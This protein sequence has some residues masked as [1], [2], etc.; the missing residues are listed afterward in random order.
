M[1]IHLVT[2]QFSIGGGIEHIF[3]ICRGMPQFQFTVFGQPGPATE[4]FDDLPNVRISEKGYLPQQVM[5]DAPDLVHIHHLKPLLSFFKSPFNNSHTYK[6]PVLFTAHG[7]HIHKYEFYNTLSARCK[8]FLRF[9]LEKKVLPKADRVIAVSREDAAFM[10]NKYGLKNVD[11]ITNGIDFDRVKQSAG[12]RGEDKQQLRSRLDL[13]LDAFLFITVARFNFQKGYDFLIR[14]LASI[15]EKFSSKPSCRFIF[16]GDGPEMTAMQSLSNQLGVTHLIQFLGAR[17]DVYDILR[18][19]DVFLLPSRWEGLPIS[20]LETG[21][22]KLPVIASDT[23]G[24][25]EII[26]KENGILFKNLDKEELTQTI[27]EVL[28]GKHPLETYAK[29]LYNEVHDNYS[30]Q[31]MISGLR[32]LY[33][34][35]PD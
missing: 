1:R 30:L 27:L 19:G 23:Y 8:Y 32:L 21:L 15:K 34:T 14:S 3:Q 24:N 18:A 12:S 11:Y 7:L 35:I 13:P 33:G 28:A 22:L 29:N 26:G 10:E 25:R 6:V 17:T 16:V 20:L 2:D 4:K 31:R 5:L 9:Q